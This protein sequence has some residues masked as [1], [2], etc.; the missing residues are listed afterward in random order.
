MLQ[1]V[2]LKAPRCRQKKARVRAYQTERIL[3]VA[4]AEPARGRHSRARDV[5]HVAVALLR[6]LPPNA[7]G[8]AAEELLQLRVWR[9]WYRYR[10]AR[11]PLEATVTWAVE[12][13]FELQPPVALCADTSNNSR[14]TTR[15]RGARTRAI[16]TART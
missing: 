2:V 13:V 15:M 6:V 16:P 9:E 14:P 12:D 8:L 11:V 3:L 10:A 5:D 4:L 1:P 7:T